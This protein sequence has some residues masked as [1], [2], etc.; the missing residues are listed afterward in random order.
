MASGVSIRNPTSDP[1]ARPAAPS[2]ESIDDLVGR[3]AARTLPHAEWTHRAHLMVGAW[4]VHRHG[5]DDA[6]ARLRAGIR[7]L[8]DAHGT[9]NTATSGYH[10]TVTRAYVRLLGEFLGAC[11]IEMPLAERVAAILAGPLAARDVLSKFYSR[12]RLMSAAARAA[13]V[14]PDLAPLRMGDDR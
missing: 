3:F 14:E 13:W 11:P 10:E 9:P 7:A 4:H 12:E 8:N 6:L 5:P 1:T 2:A